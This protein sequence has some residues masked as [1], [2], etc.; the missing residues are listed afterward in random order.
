MR[1]LAAAVAILPFVAVAIGIVSGRVQARSCCSVDLD[2][3]ARMSDRPTV[4]PGV[5]T[6]EAG[7]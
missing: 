6:L 5:G 4:S 3:D 1:F 7:R 2:H